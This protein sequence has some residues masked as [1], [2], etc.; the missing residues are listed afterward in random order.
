LVISVKK[1]KQGKWICSELVVEILQKMGKIQGV[2]PSTISP[3][4]L[5]D[6]LKK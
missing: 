6:M 3:S 2:K 5:Y 1:D 4:K